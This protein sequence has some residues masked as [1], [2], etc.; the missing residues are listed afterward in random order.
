[1]PGTPRRRRRRWRWRED[2][3]VG[4]GAVAR[5]A[6]FEVR[7]CFVMRAPAPEASR[8]ACLVRGLAR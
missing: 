6:C 3:G 4:V 8:L 7:A 5:H 2:G 1:M